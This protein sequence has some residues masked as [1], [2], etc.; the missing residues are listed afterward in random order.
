M[1][2]NARP[3]R[4]SSEEEGMVSKLS[5]AFGMNVSEVI[6]RSVRYA[7]PLFLEGEVNIADLKPRETTKEDK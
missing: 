3:V 4:L 6:R 2:K 7:G 1:M 5:K